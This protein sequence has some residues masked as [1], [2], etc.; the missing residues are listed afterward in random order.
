MSDKNDDTFYTSQ[1]NSYQSVDQNEIMEKFLHNS[2]VDGLL[3]YLD[4]KAKAV[5]IG[6]SGVSKINK[7]MP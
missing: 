4:E 2:E 5:P 1:Y 6:E 3:E 7:D